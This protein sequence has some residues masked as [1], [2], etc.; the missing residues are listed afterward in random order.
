MMGRRHVVRELNDEQFTFVIE[1]IIN[2][3]TDREISAAFEQRF[4]QPLAK[5]SLNRWR[6]QAGNELAERY[7]LARYQAAQLLTD[8]KSE[9]ADRFQIVIGN[10]EDRLLTATREV[11]ASDP[12]KLLRIRLDEEKR[13]LRERELNLKERQLDFELTKVKSDQVNLKDLPSTIIEH[14]LEF[15]DDEPTGLQWFTA[16]AKSLEAFLTTKYAPQAE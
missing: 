10:I 15:I 2:G 3:R 1:S 13:R 16:K 9:D 14:L 7:R 4:E 6:E 8:L 12:V 5:S 11:I